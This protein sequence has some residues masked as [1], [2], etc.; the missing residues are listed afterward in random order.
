MSNNQQKQAKTPVFKKNEPCERVRSMTGLTFIQ[1]GSI[2]SA[3]HEFIGSVPG[4][5]RPSKQKFTPKKPQAAKVRGF[6]EILSELDK[7]VA[8]ESKA[9]K[10]RA[11]ASAK[12]G[13]FAGRTSASTG[14]GGQVAAENQKSLNAE[15]F[16]E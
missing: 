15:R 4:Y 9:A 1:E 6:P 14:P 16:A 7:K 11:R 12:M 10:I 5:K 8:E 13:A 2:F 3:S